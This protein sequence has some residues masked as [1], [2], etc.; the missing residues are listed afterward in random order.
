MTTD[1]FPVLE[2]QGLSKHFGPVEALSG[3]DLTVRRGEVLALLGDNGA[4][5]TTLTRC[6]SGLYRATAGTIRVDGREV[7]IATP[8]DA[9]DCGIETVHQGLALVGKLDVAANLFLHREIFHPN[10]LLRA[11]GWLD[12]R[13]MAAESTRILEQLKVRV[14][15]SGVPI[16]RLS[17]GQRQAVAI[18]RAVG[19]GKHIVILD[20]P[21]AALGVEQ[22]K[23]VNELILTLRSQGVAVLLISHNMQ[24][25]IETC[26]RAVVLRHGRKAGDVRIPDVTARDLVDLI[27]GAVRAA[28]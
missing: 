7:Q 18:G 15:P 21:T 16:E 8:Q 11:L 1:E 10:P 5:K 9:R 19:W 23:H 22:S 6:I 12:K 13:A 26:D 2:V 14:P 4:G 20:E 24:H 17:G 28:A 27:T 3:V 25:V